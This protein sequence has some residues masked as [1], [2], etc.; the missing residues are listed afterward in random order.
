MQCCWGLYYLQKLS[1]G[2]Y[3]LA[4][5]KVSVLCYINMKPKHYWIVSDTHFNHEKLSEWNGR[6]GTWQ[7]Q[8]YEGINRIPIGDILLHLGDICIGN[9]E[10]V[11][12]QIKNACGRIDDRIKMIL[13]RGNHD[14]KGVQWYQDHG[15]DFVVDGFELIYQGYYLH[16]THRPSR[17]TATAMYNIH[18]HTHGNL[19]QSEE[20]KEYYDKNYNIDVSP[21]LVG[22][23]PVRLDLLLK[24]LK[25]KYDPRP[26]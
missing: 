17:P 14:K 19:H 10:E 23:K 1:V 9:D 6:S 3:P 11:H 2:I 26:H 21:E 20:Y 12:K 25:I 18:G 8:L 24:S 4:N 16:F 15:W 5:V 7:T 22:Y 13:V